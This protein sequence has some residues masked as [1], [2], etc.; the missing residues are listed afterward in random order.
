[1]ALD[2]VLR[3]PFTFD[4]VTGLRVLEQQESGGAR[5][6]IARNGADHGA[7]PCCEVH[8]GKL[9]KGW[10]AKNQRTEFRR[11]WHV[12]AHAVAGGILTLR[13]V[14]LCGVHGRDVGPAFR[15]RQIKL[16]PRQPFEKEPD[17]PGIATRRCG[18]HKSRDVV[19]TDGEEETLQ[20]SKVQSFV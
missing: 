8:D 13:R 17:A 11:A 10:R 15:G 7:R 16:L 18:A 4:Y 14:L 19:R 1:P 5:K 3:R 2:A 12:V 9:S 6:E 20:Y